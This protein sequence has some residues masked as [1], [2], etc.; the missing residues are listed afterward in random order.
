MAKY[1]YPAI[2]TLEENTYN[3]A[4]PD[5]PGCFTCGE[6]LIDAIDMVRDAISMWL[7]D[8]ENKNEPIPEPSD[9]KIIVYES[10][11]FISLIDADTTEYRRENDNRAVK[12]TLSIPSW[13]NAKAEKAGVNFSQILQDALKS[14]L[15]IKKQP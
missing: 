6:T 13:L 5:L 2:F 11:S 8:A 4:V 3:V 12:K 10:N 14:R 9:P 7:C 1:I 15:D